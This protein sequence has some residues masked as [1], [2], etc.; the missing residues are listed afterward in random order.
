[1]IMRFR[2]A[3][4][5]LVVPLWALASCGPASLAIGTG[6]VVARSVIQER[7]TQDALSDTE[8]QLT[9]N[10]KFL[11]HSAGLFGDISTSVVE[12]RVVLTG[13]V[14]QRG[15]RV[16]ATDLSWQTPGVVEVTDE[17]TVQEDSGAVAYAEDA[18]ISNQLRVKLLADGK[19]SSVNYSVETVDKVVHLTGLARS[20]SELAR[21]IDHASRLSGVS[22]VVS[23][24]LTIDDPRRQVTSAS[25]AQTTG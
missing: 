22:K 24:V 7:S 1:M 2:P 5:M 6:A 13:S 12:G 4:W 23:H 14:P 8:I 18:W 17:L 20:K 3:A 25:D 19:V 21:V 11:N 9:L 10:N 15:D 16:T